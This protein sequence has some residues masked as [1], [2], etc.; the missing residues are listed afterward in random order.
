[1]SEYIRSDARTEVDPE[2]MSIPHFLIWPDSS[3]WEE[4]K[5]MKGVCG[6]WGVW[7]FVSYVIS[8]PLFGYQSMFPSNL[9]KLAGSSELR[10]KFQAWP[11]A[12][13]GPSTPCCHRGSWPTQER[14]AARD[15]SP[16][17]K[18]RNSL[19]RLKKTVYWCSLNCFVRKGETVMGCSRR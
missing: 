10:H 5:H 1:M 12:Y 18:W 8:R 7:N 14:A 19:P 2:W 13:T 15:A 6:V 9:S 16:Q 17:N 11:C 3:N 4:V